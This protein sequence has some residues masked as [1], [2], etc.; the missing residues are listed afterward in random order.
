MPIS[1]ILKNIKIREKNLKNFGSF[2]VQEGFNIKKE[3]LSKWQRGKGGD[4]SEFKELREKYATLKKA[5]GR[6]SI[7]NMRFTG[8]MTIALTIKTIKLGLVEVGF[9]DEEL[10]KAKRNAKIRPNMMT[11]SDTFRKKILKNLFKKLTRR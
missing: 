5:S 10:D 6:P 3:L 11:I 4:G 2:L 9:F 1:I 7:P 8:R